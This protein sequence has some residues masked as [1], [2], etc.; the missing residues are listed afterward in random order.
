[1]QSTALKWRWKFEYQSLLF[2]PKRNIQRYLPNHWCDRHLMLQK[3]PFVWHTKS[4]INFKIF[5]APIS[6]DIWG[7]ST[8]TCVNQ[9]LSPLC[10]SKIENYGVIGFLNFMTLSSVRGII[11]EEKLT[12]FGEHFT[13][14]KIAVFNNETISISPKTAGCVSMS[15]HIKSNLWW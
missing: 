14:N 8:R 11:K 5:N 15:L 4:N 9:P 10:L 3:V 1:M 12:F 2:W 13:K 6:R 7:V